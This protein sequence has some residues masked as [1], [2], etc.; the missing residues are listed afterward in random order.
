MIRQSPAKIYKALQRG[1]T[2][3]KLQ[4]LHATFNFEN[5]SN[6]TRMPF[7]L[8][9]VIN[10]ETLA[11]SHQVIRQ[12][13]ANMTVILIPMVGALHCCHAAEVSEIIVPGEITIIPPSTDAIMLTNPY[14]DG[15]INYLYLT[16]TGLTAAAKITTTVNFSIRNTLH[17]FIDN[18]G[19]TGCM[20]IF[21]GR[22]EALYP[23]KDAAN[24]IFV[25]VINGAFEVQGRLLEER[26]GLALWDTT[27]ADIEALSENAVILLFEVPLTAFTA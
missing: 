6:D 22:A 14:E 21:D 15:Q 18:G 19:V 1:L 9:S 20:A 2:E 8:L 12:P 3:S 10:D 11:Q 25:F 23:L 16:F 5:Y 24:G 27:E 7:G 13:E 4:R 17:Q 26:D